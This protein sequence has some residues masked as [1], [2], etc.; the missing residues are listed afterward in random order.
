MAATVGIIKSATEAVL[1]IG[2]VTPN[3]HNP[4][5][6]LHRLDLHW[7][8]HLQAVLQVVRVPVHRQQRDCDQRPVLWGPDTL[9]HCECRHQSSCDKGSSLSD[10]CSKEMRNTTQM[11]RLT[12][13]SSIIIVTCLQHW[14][15]R[16]TS[17]YEKYIQKIK[18]CIPDTHFIVLFLLIPGSVH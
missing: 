16:Q 18:V 1:G 2:G 10:C 17:R 3:E 12:K 15:L 9:W 14:T 8:L 4:Q 6:Y 11:T 5:S 7:Q 13:M